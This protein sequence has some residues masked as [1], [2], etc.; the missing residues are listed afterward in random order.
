MKKFIIIPF[1]R[2][3]NLTEAKK[4]SVSAQI[5]D[6]S[7]ESVEEPPSV[8]NYSINPEGVPEHLSVETNSQPQQHPEQTAVKAPEIQH[9]SPPKKTK[10]RAQANLQ[11]PKSKLSAKKRKD[12]ETVP[13]PSGKFWIRP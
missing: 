3:R 8:K 7:A 11:K 9:H 13:T 5:K 12:E 2:Y 1:E 10:K 4:G 6:V